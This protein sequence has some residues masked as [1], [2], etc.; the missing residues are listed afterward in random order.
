MLIRLTNIINKLIESH[1]IFNSILIKLLF[2]LAAFT[3]ALILLIRLIQALPSEA[4]LRLPV[5]SSE[6]GH[7]SLLVGNRPSIGRCLA[8]RLILYHLVQLVAVL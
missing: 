2:S 3:P 8:R 6:L 5:S 4:L 1:Y 7:R